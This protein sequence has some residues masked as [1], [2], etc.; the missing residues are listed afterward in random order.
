[1]TFLCKSYGEWNNVDKALVAPISYEQSYDKDIDIVSKN[2]N[3][4]YYNVVSNSGS[5]N[6]HKREEEIFFEQEVNAEL[7]VTTKTTLNP[8]VVRGMKNLHN[9][10]ANETRKWD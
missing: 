7:Q 8:K 6:T 10:D 2:N 9:D 3:I 1:M 5:D 4:D